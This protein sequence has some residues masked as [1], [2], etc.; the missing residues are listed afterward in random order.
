M[1]MIRSRT[2]PAIS[3]LAMS[4]PKSRKISCPVKAKTRSRMKATRQAVLK[5]L[6]RSLLVSFSVKPMNIGMFPKGSTMMNRTRIALARLNANVKAS[7]SAES[8]PSCSM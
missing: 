1:E 4:T 8:P 7:V 3:K 5:T 6:R 2:P